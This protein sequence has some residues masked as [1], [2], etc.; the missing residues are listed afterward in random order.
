L[1]PTINQLEDFINRKNF[2]G[3]IEDIRGAW[4]YV[5]AYIKELETPFWKK[6]WRK[7]KK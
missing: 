4:P 3:Q 2:K 6:V 5:K 7:I 1:N